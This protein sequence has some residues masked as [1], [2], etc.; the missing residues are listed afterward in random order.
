MSWN[1]TLKPG[2]KTKGW[3]KTRKKLKERFLGMGVTRCE[4]CG[5]GFNLSFAH[6]VKRRFITTPEE[7]ET[8]ALLCC[9]C[10]DAVEGLSHE[11]MREEIQRVIDAR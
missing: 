7:L 2:K 6:R 3:E 9:I 5:S 8:V 1:S 10:H 11:G 4:R